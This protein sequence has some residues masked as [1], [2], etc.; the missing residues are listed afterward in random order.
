[1]NDKLESANPKHS[2][3]NL[4]IKTI[5]KYLQNIIQP[6]DDS[7]LV[8]RLNTWDWVT[9]QIIHWA[10]AEEDAGRKISDEEIPDLCNS[11]D[12]SSEGHLQVC[13]KSALDFLTRMGL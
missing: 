11:D 9:V 3:G 2:V 6:L 10:M 8:R 5:R 12:L 1:M 13:A 4:D 7:S